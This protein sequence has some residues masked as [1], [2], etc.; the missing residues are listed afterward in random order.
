MIVRRQPD[1]VIA[2]FGDEAVMM[3]VRSDERI[4]LDEV[5]LQI[6]EA[7]ETPRSVDEICNHLMKRYNVTPELCRT[8]VERFLG[9]L[10]EHDVVEF[11]SPHAA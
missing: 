4:G 1:W 11:D 9:E 5:A 10:R 6:W 2:K 8:E 7:I 3:S